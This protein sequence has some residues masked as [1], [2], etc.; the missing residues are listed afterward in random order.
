MTD[1]KKLEDII[2]S[3]GL[4]KVFIARELGLSPYGLQLKINGS[5]EFK[6][7]EIVKMCG[8]LGIENLADREAIFF[9][10]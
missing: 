4:K 8:V 2:K 10:S 7:S 6:A 3:K 9:K 5:S 1:T